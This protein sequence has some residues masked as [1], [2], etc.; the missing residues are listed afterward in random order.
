MTTTTTTSWEHR[1][2]SEEYH[3]GFFETI[4]KIYAKD[5][6]SGFYTGAVEETLG[7]MSGTF[8]HIMIRRSSF[9]GFQ[10]RS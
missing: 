9:V 1:Y 2:E 3:E 10:G 4:E 5:G 8:I 6:I 7:V